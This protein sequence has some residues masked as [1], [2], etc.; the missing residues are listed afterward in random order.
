MERKVGSG[1]KRKAESVEGR[2]EG[3][4]RLAG[5]S[6]LFYAL[7]ITRDAFSSNNV[8]STIKLII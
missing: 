2:A 1:R 6:I 3:R 7:S 8:S 5:G 4:K